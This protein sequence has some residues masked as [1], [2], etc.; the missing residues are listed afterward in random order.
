MYKTG[1]FSSSK[2]A[3]GHFSPLSEIKW[4][5]PSSL[6]FQ[7]TFQCLNMHSLCTFW[8][9]Y[10]CS[11][12]WKFWQPARS[13]WGTSIELCSF[14]SHQRSFVPELRTASFLGCQSATFSSQMSECLKYPALLNDSRCCHGVLFCA[15]HN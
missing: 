6:P 13:S 10:I 8:K 9:S 2:K 3:V 7:V 14:I 11:N 5:E 4:H 1:R 15:N 12:A